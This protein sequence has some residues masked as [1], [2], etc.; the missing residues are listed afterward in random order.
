MRMK[1]DEDR[2]NCR[3]IFDSA[4]TVILPILHSARLTRRALISQ[5]KLHRYTNQ[6]S[7][8]SPFGQ[9][10]RRRTLR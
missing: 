1:E 9:V 7:P 3:D 5:A 10:V 6:L 4:K 8:L 2:M